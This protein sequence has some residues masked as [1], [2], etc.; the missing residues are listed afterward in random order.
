MRLQTAAMVPDSRSAVTAIPTPA[1]PVLVAVVVELVV[2]A[3]FVVA[4]T[5]F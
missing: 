1:S 3:F 4:V 2:P 5:P